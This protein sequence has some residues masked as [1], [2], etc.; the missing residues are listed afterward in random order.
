MIRKMHSFCFVFK[1][2]IFQTQFNSGL[3]VLFPSSRQKYGTTFTGRSCTFQ[4][5]LGNEV[6]DMP[7]V[8]SEHP[9]ANGVTNLWAPSLHRHCLVSSTHF[10]FKKLFFFFSKSLYQFSHFCGER[11]SCFGCEKSIAITGERRRSEDDERTRLRGMETDCYACQSDPAWRLSSPLIALLISSP[12]SLELGQRGPSA[13]A[14]LRLS[15]FMNSPFT[16]CLLSCFSFW[17]PSQFGA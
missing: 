12:L 11:A 10:T 13:G 8:I 16:P 6:L 9:R 4:S 5:Q 3:T 15:F 2:M 7:G 1:K 14:D 17:G